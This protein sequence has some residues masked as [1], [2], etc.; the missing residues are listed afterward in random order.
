MKPPSFQFYADDFIGGTQTMTHEERGF[1]ILLL[2]LQWTQGG[3]SPDDFAR[4]GRG[5][6]QPSLTHVKSKFKLDQDGKLKNVRMEIVRSEQDEFR[7]NR[8]KSGKAGADKRWH[9]HSTAIAQPMANGMAKHSSPPPT[10]LV[11]REREFPEVPPM[12][13]KDFDA[14]ANM[15]GIPKDCADWFW[16]THDARNWVD[17]HGNPISKVEP[18]LQNAF[19][20]WR[21][22]GHAKA[23][24]NQNQNHK[25]GNL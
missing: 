14:M 2:S 6:A 13:R 18:L 4:L 24:P 11:E 7:A 1:Y 19:V 23:Q 22:N 12:S 17:T 16:N 10:P 9:S 3:I 5:I 21:K 15:R 20:K 8:S 25:G